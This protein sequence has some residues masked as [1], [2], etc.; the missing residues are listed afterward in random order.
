VS[1][2]ITFD[3]FD[4]ASIDKAVSEIKDYAKWVQRKAN[5]LAKRLADIG[6]V[7]VSLGF[8]RAVYTGEK[9]ITV[10]VDQQGPNTYAIIASGETVLIVEFGAGVT[11]G[12]GH[13]EPSVDGTAMG[14]TTYPGQKHAADPKG[15]WIPGGEHTYGN[16]PS[17]TMYMTAKELRS[18]LERIAKEVFST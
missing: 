5:E 15:W 17:M 11:Y 12:Y 10:T 16:P 18:E 8:A 7:N 9:D 4:T 13:P 3:I 14:P 6:A 2:T 1:R